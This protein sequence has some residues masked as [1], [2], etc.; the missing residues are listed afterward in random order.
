MPLKVKNLNFRL[1]NNQIIFNFN[2]EFSASLNLIYGENGIG[3]TTLLE[4][5]TSLPE[6]NCPAKFSY[7]PINSNGLIPTSTGLEILSLF[8]AIKKLSPQQNRIYQC[9]LFQKC[10]HTNSASFS[11][12][13]RQIFKYYLHTYWNPEII[14]IDEPFSFLDKKNS[15]LVKE[16]LNL[17]KKDSIIFLT[18]QSQ[19]IEGLE[20]DTILELKDHA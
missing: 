15:N 4:F 19:T 8:A 14:L 6:I 2:H 5:L 1:N 17:R 10:L 16:D 18:T 11:N 12:G 7:M 13:M 3:K 20:F 9:D